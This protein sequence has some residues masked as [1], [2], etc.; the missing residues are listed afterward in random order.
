MFLPDLQ[1]MMFSKL[2]LDNNNYI[3]E[4]QYINNFICFRLLG[5]TGAMMTIG[6]GIRELINT[7]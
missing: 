7:K 4:T 1:T 6:D 3:L 5:D 2:A